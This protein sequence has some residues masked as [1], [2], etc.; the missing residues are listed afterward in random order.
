[1]A[2]NS[3]KLIKWK[4]IS[5]KGDILEE[6]QFFYPFTAI[7]GQKKMK[8]TLIL[9]LINPLIGGA[10]IRGEKGTAKSI[11]V[12]A[13]SALMADIKVVDLPVSATEDRVVG[14]LDIEHTLKT[15]E[16]KFD[17]GILSWA[18]GNILY[19][20]EVN[21]LDDHVVD[22]LLDAA[23]MGMNIIEREGISYS[24][25]S[26]FVLVG[27]MNPEEGD[28]R[29][30]LIDRFGLSVDVTGEM[31]SKTRVEIIKRRLSYDENPENFLK[32]YKADETLLKQQVLK[33]RKLLS[34]VKVNDEYLFLTAKIV[35]DLNIDGHRADIT[36]IKTA[37]TIAAFDGRKNVIEKDVYEAAELAI[38]HR[39]RR[40]PFE[41][42]EK[43][44]TDL[45]HIT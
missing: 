38:P 39:M 37:R 16:K 41:E 13:L 3:V 6:K 36:I 22:I 2:D 25:K 29:P 30:Q 19:V 32:Q 9:N 15:G 35:T 23:A 4:F 31:D 10:L 33:A 40:L 27:T 21:L 1:M 11:A 34:N 7:A 24:H 8:N 5:W 20:D 43:T 14:T 28:L 18:D 12:R 42:F 44:G 17:P 45:S 26:R